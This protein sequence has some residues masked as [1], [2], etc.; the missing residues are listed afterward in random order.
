MSYEFRKFHG[1]DSED[2]T[3]WLA[4]LD[5]FLN[6]IEIDRNSRA[7]SAFLGLHLPGGAETWYFKLLDAKRNNFG[8]LKDALLETFAF[9]VGKFHLRCQLNST[10]QKENES[11]KSYADVIY[12]TAQRL[13]LSDSELLFYFVNGLRTA[14][15]RDVLLKTPKHYI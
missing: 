1:L 13:E 15:K 7:A 11:V 12:R 10:R 5:F 9:S 4:N 3:R 6:L 14:I 8:C 2:V